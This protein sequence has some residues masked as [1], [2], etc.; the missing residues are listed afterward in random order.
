[1]SVSS[2]KPINKKSYSKKENLVEQYL[3]ALQSCL[4]IDSE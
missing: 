4:I 3:K 1:M 2:S